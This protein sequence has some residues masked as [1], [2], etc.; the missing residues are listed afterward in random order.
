MHQP[1]LR[2]LAPTCCLS[3]KVLRYNSALRISLSCALSSQY[4][5]DA[6]TASALLLNW[7]DCEAFL[8]PKCVNTGLCNPVLATCRSAQGEFRVVHLNFFNP[9]KRLKV[10]LDI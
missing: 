10:H 2:K 8:D 3:E 7:S 1:N 9:F 6:C 4:R 5:D